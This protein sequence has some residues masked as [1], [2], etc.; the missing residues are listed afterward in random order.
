VIAPPPQVAPEEAARRESPPLQPIVLPAPAPHTKGSPVSAPVV[1]SS[2]VPPRA[3]RQ[4][5]PVLPVAL[6][7]WLQETVTVMVTASIDENGSV[8]ATSTPPASDSIRKALNAQAEAAVRQW[9]FEPAT[10]N[11][12]PIPASTTIEF[13]FAK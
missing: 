9:D 5:R 12:R 2:I 10:L 3:V 7:M 1:Q 11:G 4:V 8:T 6:K 13:Q